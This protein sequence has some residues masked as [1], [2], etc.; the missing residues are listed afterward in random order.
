MRLKQK[1]SSE[2]ALSV[3]EGRQRRLAWVSLG[4]RVRLLT[5]AGKGVPL[6]R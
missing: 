5:K 3:C 4:G 2:S 6:S 1:V